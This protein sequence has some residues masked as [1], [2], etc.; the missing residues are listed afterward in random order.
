M[1]HSNGTRRESQRFRID[2]TGNKKYSGRSEE[3]RRV[4]AGG[5]F[6]ASR[7]IPTSG[8]FTPLAGATTAARVPVSDRFWEPAETAGDGGQSATFVP[9]LLLCGS[10]ATGA[11][12][13]IPF[14]GLCV[15]GQSGK[16]D[17][18]VGEAMRRRVKALA[19]EGNDIGDIAHLEARPQY[20]AFSSPS[21]QVFS[22]FLLTASSF[23]LTSKAFVRILLARIASVACT[24]YPAVALWPFDRRTLS[25]RD[26]PS[27][28]PRLLCLTC[29][30][31]FCANFH[32]SQSFAQQSPRSSQQSSDVPKPAQAPA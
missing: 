22:P 28:F 14:F 27:M 26:I 12:S 9:G 17:A 11:R 20:F 19:G 25:R 31:L 15:S 32:I 23:C 5:D 3:V 4:S 6:A 30:L 1:V 21:Q 10:L 29:S 13:A 16:S 2:L 8:G 18:V 7:A 24:E